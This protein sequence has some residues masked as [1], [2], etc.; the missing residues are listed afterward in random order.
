MATKMAKIVR[1]RV[2][3]LNVALPDPLRGPVPTPFGV[4]NVALPDPLRGPVPTPFGVGNVALPDPLR[5]PV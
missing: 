5:G 2:R 1:T 4:G 3:T